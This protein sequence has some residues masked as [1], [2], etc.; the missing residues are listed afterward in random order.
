MLPLNHLLI[1]RFSFRGKDVLKSIDGPTFLRA[2]DPLEPRR[3]EHR[4]RLFEFTCLPSVL[5][6]A[7]QNFTWIIVVDAALPERHHQRLA[8]LVR[9][10][11]RTFIHAFDP[12]LSLAQ[13]RWLGNYYLH[14]NGHVMTTNLDDDDCIPR[15]FV[16]ALQRRLAN[17]HARGALPPIGIIGAKSALEWDL[18]PSAGAPLGWKA[19]WHRHRWVLSVGFSLYCKVPDFDLC[20]LGLRHTLGDSYLQFN[21]PPA[22]LNVHW[23]RRTVAAAAQASNLDLRA[24]QPES[25]FHDISREVGAVLLANHDDNDQATRLTEHK[26]E[27]VPVAGE[28]DFP[29]FSIDWE[30]ARAFAHTLI[31]P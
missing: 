15:N 17:L 3:L 24:W 4:F 16:A 6:Q 7:D 2:E 9:P 5:G 26:A 18:L 11:P 27:R 12:S 8:A 30:K 28:G 1:T 25:L 19:P 20:V 13:L 14:G 31:T 23:F 10:R 29:A 21:R 22:N